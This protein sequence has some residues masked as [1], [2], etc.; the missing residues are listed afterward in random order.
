MRTLLL[1][2]IMFWIIS[3]PSIPDVSAANVSVP[4]FIPDLND[5]DEAERI[6]SAKAKIPIE[7]RI[8]FISGYFLGRRYAPETKNRIQKQTAQPETKC[9]ANNPMPIPVETLKTSLKYLDCMT[10]V[11]HVLAL[12]SSKR[13]DYLGSFLPLLVDVMFEADGTLLMNHHRKH[14]TSYWA[15]RNERKG[16]LLNVSRD[17]GAALTR[18]V[19]LNK[20][21]KNRTF[22]VE[23]RFM[24]STNPQ[25][26]R[27]FPLSIA[28]GNN[29]PLLSGDILALVCD[30]EGL[31]VIH[32]GF[33]IKAKGKRLIRHA[34]S[35]L[36]RVVEEDLESYLR[37]RKN[38][39]GLMV[40]RPI[41]KPHFP[42]PYKFISRT[43]N[44]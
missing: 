31:D 40:L 30:K 15:D 34:S 12:A 22:Y 20:V 24:I 26:I 17:H 38:V 36:N 41:F 3:F 33:F 43:S 25:I 13:A 32:M 28:L 4:V 14:F 9:E 37:G 23:D 8:A 7:R 5:L 35:K 42:H 27:Y 39:K 29:S 16:Y 19:I 6:I 10:Y 18:E 1:I 44:H 21:G 11:E 2:F